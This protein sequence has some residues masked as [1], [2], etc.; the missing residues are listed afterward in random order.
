[1]TAGRSH[2]PSFPKRGLWSNLVLPQLILLPPLISYLKYHAYSPVKP[3]ALSLIAI[4]IGLGAVASSALTLGC[5]RLR[6]GTVSLLVVLFSD[7]QMNWGHELSSLFKVSR[8][9][10]RDGLAAIAALVLIYAGVTLI[11]WLLRRYLSTV[12]LVFFGTVFVSAVLLP[13][14]T[15]LWG[16]ERKCSESPA[17]TATLPP[18][19]HLVLDEHIG[20]GGLPQ[21]LPAGQSQWYRMRSLYLDNGFRLFGRVYSRFA[22]T[23]HSLPRVFNFTVP[24]HEASN[25]F[26]RI[27]RQ[28]YRIRVYQPERVLNFCS[29]ADF[30]LCETYPAF[31]LHLLQEAD[32]AFIQKFALVYG[33]YTHQSFVYFAVTLAYQKVAHQMGLPELSFGREAIGAIPSMLLLQR[34]IEE[35]SEIESGTLIFAHLLLPHSPYTYDAECALLPVGTPWLYSGDPDLAPPLYNTSESRRIRYERY[36][37]QLDC[38]ND[39]LRELFDGMKRTGVWDNAIV[40]VH[41]DHGSRIVKNSPEASNIKNL[42]AADFIDAFSVHFAIKRNGVKSG[43]DNRFV[44]LQ[45]LFAEISTGQPAQESSQSVLLRDESNNPK[46]FRPACMPLPDR[47]PE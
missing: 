34:V 11:F 38:T 44:S 36:L 25:Y 29:G 10:V 7:I 22:T 6:V 2:D 4:T 31:S 41:G 35:A 19:V 30:D 24:G 18:I 39:K 13:S 16:R 37:D 23:P 20:L 17:K 40:I 12:L 42:E 8:T 5:P 14:E 21:D 27:A 32:V 28:G 26:E 1:M 45:A 9:P 46:F 15:V 47:G 33:M 43:M 3:E